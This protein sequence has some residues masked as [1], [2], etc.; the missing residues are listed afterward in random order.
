MRAAWTEHLTLPERI[1]QL[2][3]AMSRYVKLNNYTHIYAPV[4]LKSPISEH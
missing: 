4:H 1:T 3:M 2:I